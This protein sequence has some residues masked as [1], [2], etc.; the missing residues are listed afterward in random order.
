MFAQAVV[1]ARSLPRI[2]SPG[3]A[4]RRYEMAVNQKIQSQSSNSIWELNQDYVKSRY[5]LVNS[6]SL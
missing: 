2:L 1:A 6:F 3:P 5:P 4:G